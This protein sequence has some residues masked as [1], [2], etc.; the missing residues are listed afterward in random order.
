MPALRERVTAASPD[1]VAIDLHLMF[2]PQPDGTV[3]IG[4]THIRDTVA[5]PFQSED[6]FRMLLDG[7]AELFGTKEIDVLERW[8]G[9]YASSAQR[10]F[11]IAEPV[12]RVHVRTVTTGIGMTTSMGFAAGTLDLITTP[13]GA[14]A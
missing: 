10:E 4:D 11:L 2:T 7:T 1:E 6:G 8:Q 3:L 9:V 12:P 5:S 14:L 13:E